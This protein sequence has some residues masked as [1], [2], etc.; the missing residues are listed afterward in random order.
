MCWLPVMGFV[1]D[2]IDR[3]AGVALAMSLGCFGYFSLYMLADP[4]G[5]GMYV[6]AVLVGMGE[7]SANLASL[8]LIGTVA[9][10][11]G[12]GAVI[13]MFSLCGAIGIL[14]IAKVG[15][16]LSGMFG[17]IA[18]FVLVAFANATVMLLSIAVF[19]VTRRE[20]AA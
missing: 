10:V 17:T 2:R 13:G 5:P 11:K 18:P 16:I 8:T 19:L 12:R 7:I 9:P 6:C 3:V 1:L 4:L 20:T 14:M 15:G